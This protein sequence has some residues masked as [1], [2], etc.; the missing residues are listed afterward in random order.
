MNDHDSQKME[1]SLR[2][3]GYVSA[4]VLSE[5]DVVVINTCSIRDRSYQKAVSHIGLTAK[6]ENGKKQIVAVTGCIVS[7]DGEKIMK[8][9]PSVDLVLGPDHIASLPEMVEEAE[10]RKSRP[11]RVD[12]TDISDYEFPSQILMGGRRVKAHVTIMKGCD[13]VCSFCIVPFTRGKEVS[14]S[15]GD[16]IDEIHRLEHEGVREVMLLGQNVNSYG[17]TLS[18]RMSFSK[19]LRRIDE[20]TSIDRMRFTSPHP[21]DLSAALIEEYGRSSKLCPHMHLPVQSGSDRILKKMRRSY[22][23][24]T[25]LKKVEA[26]R[27]VLPDVAITSDVIVGFPGETERNFE[28]TLSLLKEVHYDAIYSFTYSPRPGTEAAAIPDDVPDSVKKERLARL[29]VLQEELSLRKNRAEVGKILP[30][31][32][33]GASLD[34]GGQMSGRTP[35]ARIVN[36]DGGPEMT[37]DILEV[38]ITDASA[39]S[40]KG[41]IAMA[42]SLHAG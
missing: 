14:R 30:V 3:K 41:R 13:N 21:K 37:G 20:E 5:A 26:L 31:L 17:K 27:R 8:R 39:Y 32:V 1:A 38:E 24:E 23:R 12:F 25:Y 35:H 29:Q 4:V 16:V 22:T 9:F 33:E 28:E 10:H 19:L 6:T 34:A 40:L 18:D 11:V 7:H 42:R 15:A 36:F 2:Q